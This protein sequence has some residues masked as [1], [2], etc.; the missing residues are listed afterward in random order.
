MGKAMSEPRKPIKKSDV[1]DIVIDAAFKIEAVSRALHVMYEADQRKW[2]A[3]LEG[4]SRILADCDR[5]LAPAIEWL[6]GEDG[7]Q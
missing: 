4:F 3:A 2:A 6:G 7:E 5:K 1:Y